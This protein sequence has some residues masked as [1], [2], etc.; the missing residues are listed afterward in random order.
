MAG[1]GELRARQGLL[2]PGPVPGPALHRDPPAYSCWS[3]PPWRSAPSPPPSCRDR[4]DTQAPP[5]AR[6][7]DQ[8]PADPGLI[9]LTVR[10]VR[11]LLA[12]ALNRPK[13]TRPRRPL[14]RMATPPPGTIS[15]VPPTR[16]PGTQLCPGQLAIGCC[17]TSPP[18]LWPRASTTSW[19]RHSRMLAASDMSVFFPQPAL[20][21]AHPG[22]VPHAHY[23][24]SVTI[25]ASKTRYPFCSVGVEPALACIAWL[26]LLGR[27]AG[28]GPGGG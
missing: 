15:L 20:L 23:F 26:V 18:I 17:R 22:G 2:R 27:A 24:L 10:E 25:F 11:R 6:P 7:D 4:T 3:W 8:P 1:G 21:R 9:P 5:P 16:T 12:A 13:P 14:A 28:L 19:P